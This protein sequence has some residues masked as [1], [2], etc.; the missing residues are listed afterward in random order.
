MVNLTK[1]TQSIKEKNIK[2]EWH[3]INLDGKIIGRESTRIAKLLQG[4]HKSSYVSYLDSGDYVVVINA[5]KVILTGKKEQTKTYLKYSGYPGGLK[6]TSYAALM[7]KDPT[8]I[9]R[10]AVSGMLPKNKL[11]NKRMARLY[12]FKDEKNPYKEKFKAK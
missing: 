5:K 11:R 3:L 1:S 2:R 4:K 9:I 10:H 6:E 12:L 7:K 8:E